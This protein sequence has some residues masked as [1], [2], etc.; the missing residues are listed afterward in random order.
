MEISYQNY[1]FEQ[2][3]TVESPKI[4]AHY[5]VILLVVAVKGF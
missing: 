5:E 2:I 3:L 1:S 4:V